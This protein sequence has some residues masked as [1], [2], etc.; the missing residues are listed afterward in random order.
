MGRP[1]TNFKNYWSEDHRHLL[2]YAASRA[3]RAI[4]ARG[5]QCL[6]PW[7]LMIVGW[8]HCARRCRDSDHLRMATAHIISVMIKYGMGVPIKEQILPEKCDFP[9]AVNSTNNSTETLDIL[10]FIV[11]NP[12]DPKFIMAAKHIGLGVP[13]KEIGR[14][15][16]LSGERVRQLINEF[17]EEAQEF[18]DLEELLEGEAYDTR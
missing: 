7:D 16:N 8:Y 18:L 5:G 17:I 13:Y 4:M 3:N 15:F 1:M 11:H 6:D 10:S 2:A 14:E 9:L 12:K